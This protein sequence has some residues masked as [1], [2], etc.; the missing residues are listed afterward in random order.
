M[1][2]LAAMMLAVI[3][4][5]LVGFGYYGYTRWTGAV[6]ADES[7]TS[8]VEIINLQTRCDDPDQYGACCEDMCKAFCSKHGMVYANHFVNAP[9]C[10]CWCD[11]R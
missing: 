6:T 10:S 9:H 2:A 1:N 11:P 7:A 4:V 5:A 8:I 3:L